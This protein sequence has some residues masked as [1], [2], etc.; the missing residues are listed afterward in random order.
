M[1]ANHVQ[2]GRLYSGISLKKEHT[3]SA[4][5]VSSISWIFCFFNF[6]SSFSLARSRFPTAALP[7]GS[8][9]CNEKQLGAIECK[10]KL[11]YHV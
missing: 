6:W 11:Q 7:A 4:F 10:K 5:W 1:R 8:S 2:K 9:L 3:M